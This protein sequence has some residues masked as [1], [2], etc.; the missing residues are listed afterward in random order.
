MK[1]SL[2]TICENLRNLRINFYQIS[3]PSVSLWLIV[4]ENIDVR[5][6][7]NKKAR[8]AMQTGL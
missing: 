3:V 8:V 2:I 7:G 1:A 6:T 4:K 5:I